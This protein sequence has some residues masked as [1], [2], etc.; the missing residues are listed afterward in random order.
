MPAP[1]GR[2][3][4]PTK[5]EELGP[6]ETI[7]T[8]KMLKETRWQAKIHCRV[9]SLLCGCADK[10]HGETLPIDKPDLFVFTKREPLGVI[11]A[12]VPWNSQLFLSRSRSAR[13]WLRATPW[14]PESVGIRQRR[15]A[16]VR[17]ADRAK[18][19]YRTAWSILSPAMVTPAAG[20]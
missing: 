6:T 11:A 7:D 14:C 13:R 4:W 19:A 8:G 2:S 9:L 15:D 10:I 12:V 3:C 1:P 5:S 16:G 20:C 17:Q 18:P